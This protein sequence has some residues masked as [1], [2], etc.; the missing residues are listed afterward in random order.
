MLIQQISAKELMV[1]NYSNLDYLISRYNW[2]YLARKIYSNLKYFFADDRHIYFQSGPLLS[3]KNRDIESQN[4]KTSKKFFDPEPKEYG[5]ISLDDL[6][7]SFLIE[8]A[9]NAAKHLNELRSQAEDFYS[10][11]IPKIDKRST[12][13]NTMQRR[14][15]R[16]AWSFSPLNSFLKTKLL[17]INKKKRNGY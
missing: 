15:I 10:E 3:E 12:T 7:Y 13:T 9:P 11:D 5:A 17:R 4:V 14:R 16:Y 8:F 2:H 1:K 6:I